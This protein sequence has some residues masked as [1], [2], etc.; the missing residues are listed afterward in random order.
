MF[1]I[2][3]VA[4]TAAATAAMVRYYRH[5]LQAAVRAAHAVWE[6]TE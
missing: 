1:T 5:T 3:L 6:E 4:L 2:A